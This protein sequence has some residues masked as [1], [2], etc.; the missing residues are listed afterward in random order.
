MVKGVKLK[1]GL[2]V[3]CY[4]LPPA[5]LKKIKKDLT[6]DNPEYK[7]AMKQGR[8]IPA[9]LTSHITLFEMEKNEAWVPR[10]YIY[11]L[12]KWLRENKYEVKVKDNTLRLK[13]L[14]LEFLGELRPYQNEAV[15]DGAS[16]P[17]SVIEAATGSGK[18]CMAIWL[19]VKRQQ[20]T[21]IIVHSKE[22]LYQWQD[23]LLK[24][25]G[26]QCGLIGDGKFKIKPITVGII[27][28]VNKR[29]DDLIDHFG[30]IIVDEVH[31]C[32]SK[33]YM[34]T[35]QNFPARHYL[36]LSAT[37][38]RRDGLG[39]TIFACI[40][41]KKHTVDKKMLY[42][43]GAVLVPEVRRIETAFSY[44]FTNDYSTM[45]RHLAEDH[46][47]NSLICTTIHAD[48]KKYNEPILIVSDRKKHCETI[49]KMLL[50]YYKIDAVVLTG[51][52][53]KTERQEIVQKLRK[54]EL[55][56]VIATVTLVS[57]GFDLPELNAL[58]MMTPI[59]F[60]GKVIQLVGR[61][62]RPSEHSQPRIYDFRDNYVNVLK[63]SGFARDRVYK[64]EGM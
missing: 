37:T 22:L 12:Q 10:G 52:V 17:V 55:R 30:H 41:P 3:N 14:K 31:K 39:H 51:T 47:R 8:Y 57:E 19:I 50:N 24:F 2:G 61:I 43:T 46:N 26:E 13:K 9:S 18:T 49:Q 35:L 21:L 58:F 23:Q 56:I 48:F 34:D 11:F 15:K 16:Y 44:M 33:T 53:K 64:A 38:F 5:L 62:R 36:G 60:A 59:K 40:G 20:P 29:V 27:N 54:G 25:T 7:S 1:V 6:F 63:Y 28:T 4:N 45:I 42:E 32:A